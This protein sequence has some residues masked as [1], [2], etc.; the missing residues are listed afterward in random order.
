MCRF[1][2]GLILKDRVFVPNGDSHTD[3]L[4]ELEI[5]DTERNASNLFVRAELYPEDDDIFSDID[6]WKFK[7]DQDILPPWF[8]P[9]YDEQRMRNAVK[10]WAKD[11][12]FVGR[13]NLEFESK[14]NL[15][16]KNCKWIKLRGNSKA[17]FY[18]NSEAIL[19]D[20]SR[21]WLYDNSQAIL[22]D[23]SRA[24]LYENSKAELK[25]NSE[26]TLYD[27]SQAKLLDC[28][29]AMLNG[30]SRAELHGESR[31]VLWDDSQAELYNSS[32]ARAYGNNIVKLYDYSVVFRG[33]S[34]LDIN[35]CSIKGN[36]LIIDEVRNKIYSCN[37]Y[38]LINLKEE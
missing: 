29:Y 10:E 38:K 23:S 13:V 12:I 30:G 3:M 36:A 7:V 15:R 16:F 35:M 31:V 21:A 17:C 4:E 20:S 2:S 6:T 9:E 25:G 11:H 19:F 14:T 22:F 34:S 32:M 37:D 18:G 27:N 1:K 8:V 28:N 5:E 26:A 33:C 24:E